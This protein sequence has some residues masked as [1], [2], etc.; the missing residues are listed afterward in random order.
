MET[1]GEKTVLIVELLRKRGVGAEVTKGGRIEETARKESQDLQ[2][3]S[4]GTRERGPKTD[5]TKR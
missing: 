3:E 5:L 2:K 1:G 4:E